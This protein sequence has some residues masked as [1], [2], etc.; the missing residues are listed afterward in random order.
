MFFLGALYLQQILGYDPLEVGLAFL[1][2]TIVMGAM[3][4]GFSG[5]DHHALRREG[6]ARSRAS[7]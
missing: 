4:V 6:V 1:P 5:R 7:R 2:A 3:S